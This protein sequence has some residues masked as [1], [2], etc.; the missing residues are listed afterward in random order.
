M[1][2]TQK[3]IQM[4]RKISK[5]G[6][7]L[8][9]I[10]TMIIVCV[11]SLPTKGSTLLNDLLSEMP[12]SQGD[13]HNSYKL[14]KIADKCVEIENRLMRIEARIDRLD[15][16][17]SNN[18]TKADKFAG[19]NFAG[20]IKTNYSYSWLKNPW[21]ECSRG[22]GGGTQTRTIVCQRND[23]RTVG[24]YKCTHKR[25][26]I[27]S[28]ACN[29]QKCENRRVMGTKKDKR[30]D[31]KHAWKK[32]GNYKWTTEN[33]RINTSGSYCYNEDCTNVFT[34]GRL[35][36]HDAAKAACA[37]LG[38]GWTLPDKNAWDDLFRSYGNK[39]SLI[40]AGW[41]DDVYPGNRDLHGYFDLLDRDVYFWSNQESGTHKAYLYRLSDSFKNISRLKEDK[42]WCYSVRCVQ[43]DTK[44]T[45]DTKDTIITNDNFDYSYAWFEECREDGGDSQVGV[46]IC[47][48]NDG[49]VVADS[50]C[51]GK[52]KPVPGREC[53]KRSN[54]GY[55]WGSGG[56][57]KCEGG[58]P[59]WS[60]WGECRK[61]F[62]NNEIG[63]K[64]RFCN[65]DKGFK[66]RTVF[67]LDSF[68][69]RVGDNNCRHLTKPDYQ[70]PCTQ[71]CD[72][73]SVQ[74]CK[75]PKANS[76]SGKWVTRPWGKCSAV[77]RWTDYGSC[78][79]WKN[80]KQYRTCVRGKGTRRR[81]V[82]CLDK[83]GKKILRGEYCAEPKP[84]E[85]EACLAPECVG[86]TA[87]RCDA[88]HGQLCIDSWFWKVEKWGKCRPDNT[89][90]RDV[91]CEKDCRGI[92]TSVRDERK[93]S[94]STKPLS[95]RECNV[96]EGGKSGGKD[97]DTSLYYYWKPEKWL[98]M[99]SSHKWH[100]LV[101]SY[102]SDG[103]KTS[104]RECKAH[105]GGWKGPRSAPGDCVA[106]P[107]QPP[108]P[109]IQK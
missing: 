106:D 32:I 61:F 51:A 20:K 10:T 40:S 48:R 11:Y 9:A 14:A 54:S 75:L 104:A 86:G 90:T 24:N 87:R 74:K 43:H 29:T 1:N 2:I 71:Y 105:I 17:S 25:K 45:K 7:V 62:A 26:P 27:L 18:R 22:C 103:K 60:E 8:L 35:Y 56:W 21:E 19:N 83:K 107:T 64:Q 12:I 91:F 82:V 97:S 88:P 102:R 37:S 79:K 46:F 100:L 13:S 69:N 94:K 6:G 52:T 108:L 49:K 3:F 47:K 65:T 109:P 38:S 30:D 98:C 44:D 41:F 89:Q 95:S 5:I 39:A 63:Q 77:S 33:L 4:R 28:R 53:K 59:T 76:E 42:D 78:D 34:H 23:G 80:G 92:G 84:K 70:K 68:N 93:C 72:G 15:G 16:G 57:G 73:E 36:T 58:H 50:H 85:Y 31:H 81:E 66:I 55:H 96:Q 101:M 67:C 99:K